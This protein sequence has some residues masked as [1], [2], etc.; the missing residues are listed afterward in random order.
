MHI[1]ALYVAGCITVGKLESVFSSDSCHISVLFPVIS[2]T[3]VQT[4]DMFLMELI[5]L[6]T[7]C[8]LCLWDNK[9]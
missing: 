7:K 1:I 5:F 2:I 6:P 4:V 8:V 3:S 9:V